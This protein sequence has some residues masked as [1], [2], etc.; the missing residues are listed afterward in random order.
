MNGQRA[1]PEPDARKTVSV[2]YDPCGVLA[3][4]RCL[5]DSSIRSTSL[6]FLLCRAG[7]EIASPIDLTAWWKAP[8]A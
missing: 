5:C 4:G 7:P 3:C 8:R 2:T 6:T 1:T